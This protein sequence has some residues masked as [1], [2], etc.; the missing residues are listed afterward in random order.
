MGGPPDV[1]VVGAGGGGPVVAKE[2]AERGVQVLMLE[3]GPWFD[4]DR[5]FTLLE[6][7]MFSIV[8]GRFRWGPGDRTRAPWIR[9]RDGVG[10]ILQTA[11]VGGTTLHYNGISPRAYPH[12]LDDSPLAYA[13]LVPY[14]E[15]VEDFLP[16]RQVD[17]GDL[18]PK[19][20]L[21]GLGCEKIGLSHSESKDV[22]SQVWRRA[23]NAILPLAR[24]TPGTPLTFPEVEGCTM[25]GKRL[26]GCPH[27]AGAP[28]ERK[29]KR[30]TNVSY[31]P[32]AVATGNCQVVPNAYATAVL[33]DPPAQG[34]G[35]RARVRGVRWRDTVSGDTAEA[36]APV[37]VLAAG[38]IESPRLWM[39]SGLPNSDDVVGRY[40]TTHLQDVVTGFFDREVHP[41][42]GQVT[43]AR[44]DFPGWGTLFSQGN[45]P[46][47][48]AIL[49]AG[50]GS[51][52]W[53]DPTGDEPWDFAG[54]WWGPEAVRK[55]REYHRTL[56]VLVC[57]DD[58]EHPDNRV[59]LADDWGADEHG[60]VP[61]VTYR[62]TARS[63]ERQ[64]WLARKGAE[65]L[66]AA[67][68]REIHRT[69]FPRALLTHIMG[70]LRMG[71]DPATSV[72]GPDGQAH[73]VAGLFV[74]DSSILP[75]GLGGPN[76]TL[77]VQALAARTAQ[78]ILA[79]PPS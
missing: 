29:A 38:A 40:L 43:M 48:V 47:A 19:D 79:R 60:P 67:G 22:T 1:I 26:Q 54:R 75:N 73:Q 16:V 3:A 25:C 17:E 24:M 64:D 51:G 50:A 44:A 45:G 72:A 36:E 69:N 62:P 66:R 61:K 20:A 41:D 33:F 58:E 68:A 6:D 56:S 7:D 4:P 53:D 12:A 30:A 34:D 37:V 55:L 57:T 74:G 78:A 11:G 27:P 65:I 8:D 46:Q 70:T 77:T 21:F 18:A 39:N 14:Y 5:D 31:V 9:R 23:H 76:P 35:G 42:V 28:V 71:R 32:A 10:L 63:K 49:L 15:Q 2:L 59:T 13:D 52:F